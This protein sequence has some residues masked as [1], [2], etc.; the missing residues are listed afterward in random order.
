MVHNVN[1]NDAGASFFSCGSHSYISSP[2]EIAR[3]GREHLRRLRVFE[4]IYLVT[5]DTHKI[6]RACSFI[7]AEGSGEPACRLPV[8]VCTQTGQA[9]NPRGL[10]L[11]FLKN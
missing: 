4:A 1:K 3:R 8:R 6:S 10:Q 9:G 11:S 7:G 5:C 2:D